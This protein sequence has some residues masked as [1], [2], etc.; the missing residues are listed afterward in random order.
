MTFLKLW[1]KSS[2]KILLILDNIKRPQKTKLIEN[3]IDLLFDNNLHSILYMPAQSVSM[4]L[5]KNIIIYLT[6]ICIYIYVPHHAIFVR[7]SKLNQMNSKQHNI[8]SKILPDWNDA[9]STIN[10]LHFILQYYSKSSFNM[11]QNAFEPYSYSMNLLS[12][13]LVTMLNVFFVYD[14]CRS[15]F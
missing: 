12:G 4:C 5:F 1:K 10:T 14:I 11:K 8:S 3:I 15:L 9:N 6:H 2:Y 7:Y 13:C